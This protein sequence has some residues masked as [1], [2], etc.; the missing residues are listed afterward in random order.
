MPEVFK[1]H[2]C[3]GEDAIAQDVFLSLTEGLRKLG[4]FFSKD[5]P[6]LE[7]RKLFINWNVLSGEDIQER[8]VCVL[9]ERLIEGEFPAPQTLVHLDHVTLTDVQAVRQ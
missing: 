2:R 1:R 8:A 3:F 6:K 4:Q 9:G 7:V 5:G